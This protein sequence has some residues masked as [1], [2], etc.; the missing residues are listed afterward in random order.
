MTNT[1]MTT[2]EFYAAVI[3]ANV[4]DEL[5]AKANEL[6]AALDAKNE[7]RRTTDTKEKK[8]A[9]ARRELVLAFLRENEGAFTR[10]DIAAAIDLEPSKVTGACTMLVKEGVVVKTEVKI[11]KA[12]KMAYQIA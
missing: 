3:A 1:T 6:I 2:R 7:K 8:E 10:D 4:S 5:T 9:A 11:D 12:R